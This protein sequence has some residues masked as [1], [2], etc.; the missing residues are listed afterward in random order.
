MCDLLGFIQM[1]ISIF[2]IQE[3]INVK[4]NLRLFLIYEAYDILRKLEPY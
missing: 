2:N 1:A 4:I 3:I